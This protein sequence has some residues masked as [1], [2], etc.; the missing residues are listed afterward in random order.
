MGDFK[1]AT[2]EEALSLVS[3]AMQST[4]RQASGRKFAA[5]CGEIALA[6]IVI[7]LAPCALTLCAESFELIFLCPPGETSDY[8]ILH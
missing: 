8:F 7:K 4:L 2:H 1:S 5:G 3:S 6:T